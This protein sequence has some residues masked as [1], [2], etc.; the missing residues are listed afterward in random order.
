M[1]PWAEAF[2]WKILF[3]LG[4]LVVNWGYV[5]YTIPDSFQYSGMKK[6]L[7]D[8][9]NVQLSE[10]ERNNILSVAIIPLKIAS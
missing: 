6:H 1:E 9:R 7:S 10:A 3:S 8:I 5:I 2:I 4:L